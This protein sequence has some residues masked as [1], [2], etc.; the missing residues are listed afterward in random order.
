MVRENLSVLTGQTTPL[1]MTLTVA[2]LAETVTVTG[3]S[4]VVDTTSAN[5]AST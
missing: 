4:P 1:D 5:V 3:A 2:T